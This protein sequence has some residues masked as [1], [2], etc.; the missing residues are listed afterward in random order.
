MT[1]AGNEPFDPK[2]YPDEVSSPRDLPH[3]LSLR[4]H[5]L[6]I[7]PLFTRRNPLASGWRSFQFR[8]IHRDSRS[9]AIIFADGGDQPG[10]HA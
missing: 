8:S 10:G 5:L 2:R 1:S 6:L 3:R 9:S 7:S 4:K